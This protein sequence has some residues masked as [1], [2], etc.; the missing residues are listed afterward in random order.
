MEKQELFEKMSATLSQWIE[1]IVL[2]DMVM[3]EVAPHN[4]I[5]LSQALRDIPEFK[6]EQCVDICGVDF[7]SYGLTEWRTEE[8]T[9][10]GF[11][12]ATDF[13]I[14]YEERIIDWEKPRFAAIYHLLSVTHNHRVRLKVFMR[15][16]PILPS[17]VD[18]W[19]SANWYEREAFDLFGIVFEGHPDLRRLLTDYG[20]KGHPFRKDFP[21]IGQVEMRYDAAQQRCIYEPVSIRQRVLVPKV[22]RRDSRYLE[23]KDKS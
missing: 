20:F 22:I 16:E 7:L 15:P 13:R 23:P 10:S 1:N 4:L 14:K 11:N 18:V 19:P 9:S 3:I 12:R 17:V 8:T 2:G 21:L 6:F 5:A